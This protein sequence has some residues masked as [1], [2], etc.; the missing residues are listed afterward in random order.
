MLAYMIE[1][2]KTKNTCSL[3]QIAIVCF[4]VLTCYMF[5]SKMLYPKSDEIGHHLVANLHISK[6]AILKYRTKVHQEIVV[7]YF[8]Q[9]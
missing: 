7:N 5:P 1:E 3:K 4:I 8:I 9:A 6:S 2:M